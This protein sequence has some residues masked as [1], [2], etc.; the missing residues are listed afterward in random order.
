MHNCTFKENLQE[1]ITPHRRQK[2][3]AMEL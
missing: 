1:T 2:M 3:Q